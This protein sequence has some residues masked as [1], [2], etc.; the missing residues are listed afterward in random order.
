[1]SNVRNG[2]TVSWPDR[3]PKGLGLIAQ[4]RGGYSPAPRV[5]LPCPISVAPVHDAVDV[6]RH[7]RMGDRAS[8]VFARVS[9]SDRA[10]ANSASRPTEC[11][12]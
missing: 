10:G 3:T 7:R 1:M 4:T 8:R 12:A 5:R 9:A 6:G 2:C 11:Q